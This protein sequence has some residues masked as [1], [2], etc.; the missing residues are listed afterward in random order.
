MQLV[1]PEKP[2][3]V[4][5]KGVAS[6]ADPDDGEG[7]PLVQLTLTLTEALLFGTKSLCTTNVPLVSVLVIVHVPTANDAKQVPDEL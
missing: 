5:E 2:A 3:I 4:V 1:L 7:V 6:E